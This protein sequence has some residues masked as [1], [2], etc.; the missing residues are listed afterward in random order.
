MYLGIYVYMHTYMY[1]HVTTINEK[2]GH[3]F[4]REQKGDV[5]EERQERNYVT[6][7]SKIKKGEK[8]GRQP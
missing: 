7:I 4:Q 5:W 3:E 6:I 2:R 8:R 1:I